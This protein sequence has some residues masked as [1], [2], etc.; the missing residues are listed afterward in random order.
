[1]SQVKC[2]L[3]KRSQNTFNDYL[4]VISYQQLSGTKTTSYTIFFNNA[5][6]RKTGKPLST[7]REFVFAVG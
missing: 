3:K 1:M 2:A 6:Y 4:L 5:L 7:S